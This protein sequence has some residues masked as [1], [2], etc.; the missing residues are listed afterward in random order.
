[1]VSV[2]WYS[3]QSENCFTSSTPTMSVSLGRQAVVLVPVLVFGKPFGRLLAELSLVISRYD[4]RGAS[5]PP[6]DDCAAEGVLGCIVLATHSVNKG[7][8]SPHTH[9]I[10]RGTHTQ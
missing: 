5:P 2:A 1:M 8:A 4:G 6:S 10:M 3:A 7:D 9:G